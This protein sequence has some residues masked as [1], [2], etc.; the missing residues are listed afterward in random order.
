MYKEKPTTSPVV[1]VD[2]DHEK[3]Y[4]QIELPGVKKKDIDLTVAEQGFCIKG[5]R[6]DADLSGCY[7]LVH[8][9]DPDKT[10]AKFENGLLD[11]VIPLKSP[12][13]GKKIAV[14]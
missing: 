10:K 5:S 9:V 7:F 14:E 13:I 1:C 3:Y 2:H 6:K 11:I 8:G 12:L 4:I